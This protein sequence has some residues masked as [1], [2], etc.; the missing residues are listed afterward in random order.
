MEYQGLGG[1]GFRCCQDAEDGEKLNSSPEELAHSVLGHTSLS[2]HFRFEGSMK[3]FLWNKNG[4]RFVA[5]AFIAQLAI[6]QPK[7]GLAHPQSAFENRCLWVMALD[8]W[9]LMNRRERK[10]LIEVDSR[11]KGSPNRYVDLVRTLD[12]QAPKRKMRTRRSPSTNYEV[13]FRKMVIWVSHAKLASQ[14]LEM[15][16]K[17]LIQAS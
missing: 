14:S 9:R 8:G 4:L 3:C 10:K 15:F 17:R 11:M 6:A 1:A 5:P 2:Q 16:F 12:K 7:G 13:N